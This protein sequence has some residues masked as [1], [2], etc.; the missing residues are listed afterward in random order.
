[1]FKSRRCV[2]KRI[3]AASLTIILMFSCS[4][5]IHAN[6][7]DLS[8][9]KEQYAQLQQQQQQYQSKINDL[10]SKVSSAQE[11]ADAI[12]KNVEAIRKQVNLLNTQI[13][14]M[15]ADIA[16]NDKEI[17]QTQERIKTN[18]KL[19][20]KRIC[21]IYETG[22]TSNIE[23][24]LSSKSVS[25]FLMKFELLQ[26]ISDYDTKII[27]QLKNDQATLV[28]QKKELQT[29]LTNLQNTQ[30]TVAAKQ[31]VLKSQLAQQQKVV[32]DLKK[33]KNA[34][35]QASDEVEEKARKTDAQINAEIARQAAARRRQLASQP[36]VSVSSSSIVS[37]AQGFY[38]M[39]YKFKTYGPD[40]FD[41]SGFVQYVFS[42]CAGINLPHKAAEQA[43]YGTP[44]SR[45][46]LQPGD[47]VFFGYGGITHV[48]IYI[49]N[50]Q[51][52]NAAN[53][54]L[55]V[56]NSSISSFHPPYRCARRII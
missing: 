32:N 35:E 11:K 54:R 18:Q 14:A 27:N 42:N 38:G 21:T 46:E 44:V 16:N 41:C 23:L 8:S 45:D 10:N 26:T 34:L 52:I 49:G 55:G 29:N 15:K 56:C 28:S 2:A 9:L 53:K 7:D 40:S 3:T 25:D 37:Y 48:G 19:Y 12:S 4:T 47:L 13:T 6:A 20:E 17:K 51:M 50:G 24:L 39:P 33:N 1:M 43:T 30:S 36:G 22:N 5:Y 31:E